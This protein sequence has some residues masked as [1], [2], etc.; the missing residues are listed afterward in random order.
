ME[1]DVLGPVEARLGDRLLD[2]GTP[3]Q[4]AVLAVLALERGRPVSVDAIIDVLWGEDPP[5]GVIAT[6]QAYVSGLRRALE[7]DRERRTPASVLVTVAPGYS[8]HVAADTLDAGRF[9]RIVTEEDRR[10]Q[11]VPAL[12]GV[13]LEG[14]LARLD[15]ALALWRGTP[16]ADLADAP[17]AA[18]ERTRLEELRLVA[19]E[20]RASVSLALGRHATLT[21]ELEALTATYPL[22][23]RLWAMRAVALFRCGRQAEALDTITQVRTLLDDELGLEPSREL[24]DL[25]TALLRQD[26]ALLWRPPPVVDGV[27]AAR[28]GGAG[29]LETPAAHAPRPAQDAPRAPESLAPWRLVGRGRELEMLTGALSRAAS[30]VPTF[31]VLTGDAGIGKTRLAGE[32]VERA[33][34]LGARVLTGRGSQDDGAPPLWPWSTVLES[35]GE[36]LPEPPDERDDDGSQFRVW[37]QITRSVRRAATARPTVLWLDDLHWADSSSLRVLRLLVETAEAERLLLLSTWRPD[38]SPML[39]DLAETLARRHATRLELG[40]LS[41]EESAEV[42]AEVGGPPPSQS[43][44][45]AIRSRTSG[46][47]FFLVEYARLAGSHGDIERLLEESP[48]TAVQEVVAR[49]L[50]RLPEQ[51][52]RA[53]RTGAVIGQRFDTATLARATGLDEDD[54]LDLI[55]PAQ[56]AGLVT[57]EGVDRFGFGHAL[58]REVL[59][60]GLPASRR[61]REHARIA[62]AMDEVTDRDTERAM[63]W[64]AAG[65]AYAAKARQACLDAAV[66]ARR[67]QAREDRAVL[68]ESALGLMGTNPPATEEERYDTLMQLADAYRW[69]VRWDDLAATVLKAVDVA[70]RLR[71]PVRLARAAASLTEGAL[72]EPE[73]HGDYTRP[74]IEALRE[75]LDLLPSDDSELRCRVLVALAMELYEEAPYDERRAL[76]DEALAMARRVGDDELLLHTL[77]VATPAL[78]K[79]STM[80]DRLA[81]A[82]EAADLADRTG[83]RI[84]LVSA[85]AQRAIALNELGRRAESDAARAVARGP[86]DELRLH[87]PRMVVE[88]LGIPWLGLGGHIEQA[89]K[90]A[91]L[92]AEL[93]SR[94]SLPGSNALVVGCGISILVWSGDYD[95]AARTVMELPSALPVESSVAALLC[96]AGEVDEARA[97]RERH[98]FALDADDWF[99][100]LNWSHAA[101]AAAYLGDAH[102]GSA[103]YDRL[104]PYAGLNSCAGSGNTTGPVDRYLA[105]AA[106]AAGDLVAATAHAREADR[107]SREWHIPV[108]L[109]LLDDQRHLFGF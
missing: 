89:R 57:E 11:D 38:S 86:A 70:R 106:F 73:S 44:A 91:D 30:G 43:Q 99:S 80:A 24:R 21:G 48:P 47:P 97:Y 17:A 45:E 42:F 68:L 83:N 49:R 9:E 96:R 36:P 32:I 40:G 8:L 60:A 74:V 92:I 13:D 31:A 65:P 33:R 37:E 1:V 103:M 50:A 20:R 41:A 87:Y 76:V 66:V 59:Y 94:V 104:L 77:L 58:V 27:P 14:A 107:L 95:A 16:Y 3:K 93:G 7:P 98:P 52:V 23:E 18:A 39:A 69:L 109:K 6:L 90:V 101:E 51:T 62:A 2:L 75:S 102:L 79:P 108:L 12:A 63:H 4:R 105:L 15:G 19:L 56:A 28:A 22:R 55:D 84:A 34:A 78:W 54:L 5:P 72:W 35:L 71:D 53:L 26:E 88:S 10:L 46:N 61:A 64:L 100:L 85:S 81:L 82:T 25:Q 29:G 67:R